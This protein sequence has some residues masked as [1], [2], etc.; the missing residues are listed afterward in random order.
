M[1]R[2]WRGYKILPWTRRL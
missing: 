2:L 1:K